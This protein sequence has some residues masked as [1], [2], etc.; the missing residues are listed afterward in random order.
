[1][2]A[3]NL[4]VNELTE[5]IIAL[6]AGGAT[7]GFLAGL[8]GIGGGSIIVPILYELFRLVGVPDDIRMHL[9]IGTSL[10]AIVPTTWRS[11]AAHKTRGAV[12]TAVVRRLAP[13]VVAG[14]GLGVLLARSAPDT[15]IKWIWVAFTATMTAKLLLGSE[16]WRLGTELPRS[17]L[18][19]A[20]G[21]FVGFISTV[22]SIAGGTFITTLLMLYNRPITAAIATATAFGPMI[23]IPGA[24]GFVWA[25]WGKPG[26]PPLS[27]GYVN[28]LGFALLVPT[29]MITAPL[30]VRAA[31]GMPRRALEL[32]FAAFL[33]LVGARFVWSL[34]G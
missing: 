24:L 30:G 1:M 22:L 16:S 25:G 13:P 12:D 6:L 10:A 4:P 21:L 19:E 20:Y 18:V 5:M 27:L 11:H 14:V 2:L 26:L 9:T 7:M 8:F 32:I 31:H 3:M 17:R 29:S 23:A 33:A 34:V 15:A 28:L